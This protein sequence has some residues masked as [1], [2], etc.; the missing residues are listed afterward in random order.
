ML[1][2]LADIKTY[3]G[4]TDN[5]YDGFLTSQEEVVSSAVEGYCN[6]VFTDTSYVETFYHEDMVG[7]Y[8]LTKLT[9]FHYPVTMMTEIKEFANEQD[10]VGVAVTDFRTNNPT[11]IVS[12]SYGGG[13]FFAD[14]K[15]LR[16]T[17]DAG[18]ATIPPLITNVVLEIIQER[19]NK[20]VSGVT[21][22]FG[23]DVQRVSVPGVL[24]VDFDY[25][26]DN[27]QRKSAFGSI[28]GSQANVLDFFRS[29]RSVVGSVK[30]NYV[31]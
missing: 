17:Y 23:N 9:L 8:D 19:Y 24:S 3:L 25:S 18:F 5:S 4:I 11:A 1:V 31:T 29:E 21:L 20:K 12:K 10:L 13:Y 30:L 26:L 15:I 22:D 28:I 14:G 2:P 16:V 27:N 7:E 6:R